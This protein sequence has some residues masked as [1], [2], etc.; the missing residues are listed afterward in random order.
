MVCFSNKIDYFF[1]SEKSSNI[2]SFRD[3]YS[4]I[5]VGTRTNANSQRSEDQ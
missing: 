3:K 1:L 2:Q 4:K 5:V